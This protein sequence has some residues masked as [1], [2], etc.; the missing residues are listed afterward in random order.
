MC[1]VG[2]WSL[3]ELDSASMKHPSRSPGLEVAMALFGMVWL[4]RVRSEMRR[5]SKCRHEE[6]LATQQQHQQQ[7]Q[8][9]QQH[10]QQHQHQPQQQQQQQ[11]QTQQQTQQQQQQQQQQQRH[12][13]RTLSQAT[14]LQTPDDG[15]ASSVNTLYTLDTPG[16]AGPAGSYCE[17]H[18]YV[19]AKE[20]ILVVKLFFIS[21]V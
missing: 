1:R 9:L 20:G 19:Q 17:V 6:M 11:Q 3:D 21:L 15:L 12:Q 8:Q 18:G 4:L 10:S 2:S 16:A 5:C 7:Q 13:Q 14:I